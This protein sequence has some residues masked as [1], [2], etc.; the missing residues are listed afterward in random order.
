MFDALHDAA[1]VWIKDAVIEFRT[2]PCLIKAKKE[3]M[4]K[5]P[6]DI[7]ATPATVLCAGVKPVDQEWTHT[8]VS[9]FNVYIKVVEGSVFHSSVSSGRRKQFSTLLTNLRD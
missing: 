9:P 1:D 3:G 4:L 5:I 6:G 2:F 8:K 7:N